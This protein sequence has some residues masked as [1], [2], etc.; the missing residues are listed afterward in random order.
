MVIAGGRSHIPNHPEHFTPRRTIST[1]GILFRR[2]NFS[3]IDITR[4]ASCLNVGPPDLCTTFNDGTKLFDH[5]LGRCINARTVPLTSVL[6][7][8]HPMNRYLIRMLGRTTHEC[9]RGNNYTNYVILRNVRDRSPRT[10]S[11]TIRC[12]RTT[13]AAVCSCV[14]EQRPR[15]TRYI[16]SFVDAIVSKLSTGTQ[17]KRSVR[18]LYTATTLTKRTVGALLGR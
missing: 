8:S 1:T 13:R 9:D 16:A 6:H 15:D 17:R 7:S 3:T 2:G 10:H 18:R 4:I 12:C 11:V 5:M 14:T